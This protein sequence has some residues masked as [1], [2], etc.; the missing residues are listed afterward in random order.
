[1]Y[2]FIFL[3][4]SKNDFRFKSIYNSNSINLE[5]PYQN[6][7]HFNSIIN[8]LSDSDLI[9]LP[10]MFTTGFTMNAFAFSGNIAADSLKWMQKKAREKDAVITGSFIVQEEGNYY[11]KL[12]A[13]YPDGTYS[14]YRKRHLFGE[15]KRIFA[16]GNERLIFR[17]GKWRICPL[18]CYDIRFPVWSRNKDDFDLLIYVANWPASRQQVW[19]ILLKARAIEN[20]CYVAG[21]NIIGT[22]GNGIGYKGESAVIDAVGNEILNMNKRDNTGVISLSLQNLFDFREKFPLFPDADNFTFDL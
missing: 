3:F 9:I 19:N 4:L 15:E 12:H 13:V 6:L 21:T 16:R 18:I 5:N 22:D 11:N 2:Y 1:M 8:S 7:D 20:Q 17:I 10:E 14:F